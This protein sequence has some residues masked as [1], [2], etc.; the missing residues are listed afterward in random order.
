MMTN[1]TFWL[2]Q[3]NTVGTTGS[4]HLL[5][6]VHFRGMKRSNIVFIIHY[7]YSEGKITLLVGKF[8][9]PLLFFIPRCTSTEIISSF[10]VSEP[11]KKPWLDQTCLTVYIYAA[12]DP[13]SKENKKN[14]LQNTFR[15]FDGNLL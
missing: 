4:I 7:S 9:T 8:L 3:F 12:E 2:K 13:W 10:A 6:V 14:C 15:N 11:K 1:G 5:S